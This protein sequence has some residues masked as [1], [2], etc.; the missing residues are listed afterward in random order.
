MQEN[1]DVAV[2][3]CVSEYPT[4]VDRSQ[5]NAVLELGRLFGV[6]SGFSDHSLSPTLPVVAVAYGARIIEKHFTLSRDLKGPDHAVALEPDEFALMVRACRETVQALST[7]GKTLTPE[8]KKVRSVSLRGLYAAVDVEAGT[9]L[10]KEHIV[11]LR[12]SATMSIR[13][14]HCVVGRTARITLKRGD[15]FKPED[16]E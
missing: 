16:L 1:Y 13:D 5:I 3:H 10:T 2:L 14:V 7:P 11:A 8:L 15:A 4:P 6:I 9:R 12:P